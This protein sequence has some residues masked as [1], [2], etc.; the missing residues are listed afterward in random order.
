[1]GRWE[2][3]ALASMDGTCKDRKMEGLER[4]EERKIKGQKEWKD[5][6]MEEWKEGGYRK[7]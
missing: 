5:G 3:V 4:L 2:D 6:N 7:T 1:M